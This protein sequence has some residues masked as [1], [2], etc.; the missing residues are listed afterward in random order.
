MEAMLLAEARAILEDRLCNLPLLPGGFPVE[1][2]TTFFFREG[3]VVCYSNFFSGL[4]LS[5]LSKARLTPRLEEIRQK[6]VTTLLEEFG[7]NASVNYWHSKS[8]EFTT[9]PA[10]NDL[11]STCCALAGLIRTNR[12]LVSGDQLARTV[13]LLTLIEAEVGGPYRTWA[14]RPTEAEVWKDVDYAV[15][16]NIAGFLALNDVRLPPL[17]AYLAKGVLEGTY[18]SAY[19]PFPFQIYYFLAQS[20]QGAVAEKLRQDIYAAELPEGGW[21]SFQRTAL[22]LSALETLDTPRAWRKRGLQRLLDWIADYAQQEKEIFCLDTNKGGV[23][24]YGGCEAFALALALEV[25]STWEK[26]ESVITGGEDQIRQVKRQI[27]TALEKEEMSLPVEL[28]PYFQ[29]IRSRLLA[30][31]QA[32][33]IILFPAYAWQAMRSELRSRI[34]LDQ[35]VDLGLANVYGWLAYTLYDDLL[36]GDANASVLPLANVCLRR[37]SRIFD[38]EFRQIPAINELY[39]QV[40]DRMEAANQWELSATRLVRSEDG[41]WSIPETLPDYADFSRLA[42]RSMGHA[43]GPISLF[44]LLPPEQVGN[45]RKSLEAFFRAYLIARQLNDDAHDWE[46]DLS[47]G[48]VNAVGV[49]LLRAW[50]LQE[51]ARKRFSRE[52]LIVLRGIFWREVSV[53]VLQDIR[54]FLTLAEEQAKLLSCF[55]TQTLIKSLLAPLWASLEKARQG[56]NSTLDFLGFYQRQSTTSIVFK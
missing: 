46:E 12:T 32:D 45:Q 34:A 53:E 47:A 44:L 4:I 35:L 6:L 49:R 43:L 9:R 8:C 13:T 52:D 10:P 39:H 33:N 23:L 14:V 48:R 38:Q 28:K 37:V 18:T 21:G 36:D 5:A 7:E 41:G 30:G 54:R 25:C 26:D 19:Y 42:E 56:R 24:G 50:K 51:P 27:E 31:S 55:Q 16:A 1:F 22:A 11:D 17:D 2:S 29:K 20:V 3:T 40:L 15:N